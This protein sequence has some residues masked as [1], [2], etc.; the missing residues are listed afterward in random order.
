M[1][2]LASR[3]IIP[4]VTTLPSAPYDGQEVYYGADASNGIIWHLRYNAAGGTYKWEFIGGSSLDT[5]VSAAATK[6]SG[7]TFAALSDSLP[8]IS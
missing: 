3:L 2:I 8:T 7:T 6:G 5:L 1:G 4:Y